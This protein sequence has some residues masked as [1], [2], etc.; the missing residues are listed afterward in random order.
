MPRV[1]IML[2]G[3]NAEH[4]IASAEMDEDAAEEK[5]AEIHRGMLLTTERVIKLDWTTVVRSNV[6]GAWISP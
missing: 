6:I 3:N 1:M 5:I 4:T 2:Q